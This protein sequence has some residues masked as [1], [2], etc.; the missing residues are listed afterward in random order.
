[1]KIVIPGPP[2]PKM[3]ARFFKKGV[4]IHSYDP[5]HADKNHTKNY[6]MLQVRRAMNDKDKKTAI[7]ATDLSLNSLFSIEMHFHLPMPKKEAGSKKNSKLWGFDKCNTKPDLDNLEKF[8]LDCANGILFH[9]DRMIISL[10][11]KK[12]YSEN[13]RTEINILPIK[14]LCLPDKAKKIITT[15]EPDQLKEFLFDMKD[16]NGFFVED[17]DYLNDKSKE[18]WFL[19]VANH[20]ALFARKHGETIKKL[21]KYK[22]FDE[23]GEKFSHGKTLC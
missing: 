22:D 12:S 16:F 19:D 1:M 20:L 7:E 11:S 3:R 17:L 23:K 4:S 13:P 8:Y 15:F 21:N 18:K 14:Q 6:M 9:D 2:V 5:Q 10:H